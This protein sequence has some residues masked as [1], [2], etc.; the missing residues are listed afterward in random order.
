M[1]LIVHNPTAGTR[2]TQ[3]RAHRAISLLEERA[4][5]VCVEAPSTASAAVQ[6]V[7][8]AL[9]T[10]VER[11]IACGGDGTAGAVAHALV[12][13][14]V[15]LGILPAGTTNVL[16]LEC[17]MPFGVVRAARRLLG[18]VRERHFRTWATPYGTLILA[19]G[20]GLDARLMRRTP[21]RLKRMLGLGA[22]GAASLREFATYDFPQL[23]VEVEDPTGAV[24][25]Y[26][27]TYVMVCN[28]KRYAGPIQAVPTADP[29][30][31]ELDVILFQ[32]RS[33]PRLVWFWARQPFPGAGHLK[34]AGVRHVRA[35][36]FR[37]EAR[38]GYEVD[39]HLNGDPCGV[40]PVEGAPG[41]TVRMLAP[42]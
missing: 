40:T 34:L 23:S 37:I 5:S 30:D 42:L 17:G 13:S 29:E 2:Y 25:V 27:A 19:L 41:G 14:T 28:T 12:G 1:W 4:P 8:E 6:V 11:V 21:S 26:E 18:P 7:R 24:A 15:P 33:R 9:T 39:V 3:W 35:R 38:A 36:R 31:D 10:G 16:A 20:V 32:S 22:V